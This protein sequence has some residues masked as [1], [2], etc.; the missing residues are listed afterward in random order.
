MSGERSWLGDQRRSGAG[1]GI[2]A[3]PVRRIA[4]RRRSGRARIGGAA[5]LRSWLV[6]LVEREER[7]E[8]CELEQRTEILVQIREAERSVRL[9]D[10]LGERDRRSKAGA[11]DVARFGK[12]DDESAGATLDLGRHSLAQLLPI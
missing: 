7:V 2:R 5:R 9:P 11:I 4:A 6:W 8:P 10:P 1:V 3:R 12:I